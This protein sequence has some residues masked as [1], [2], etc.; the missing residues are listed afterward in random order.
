LETFRRRVTVIGQK[1]F[2]RAFGA[3]KV[4]SKVISN[5]SAA[6]TLAVMFAGPVFACEGKK[7]LFQDSFAKVE[8]A[9]E[10]WKQ[11]QVQDGAMKITAQPNHIAPIFYKGDAYDKVDI[12]VDAIVPDVSDP[13]NLGLPSLLFE[14]Q[15]YDDF[16]GFYVSPASGT[17]GISR[18]LKNKWL[19]PVPFRKVDGIVA[20]RGGKNTLR[21]TLNGAHATAYVNG[22]KIVDFLINASAGGG[23][24]GL[25]VDGGEA[26]PVTWS[27]KNFKVTDLP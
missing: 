22:N 6:A 1:T 24:V 21:I 8:P 14:G 25:D 7:V 9:W 18:L 12:C 26:A 16:Y 13:K 17:A 15:A 11:T 27:F 4:I 20:Q 23:F 19:H 5:V 3:Y 2:L 10:M